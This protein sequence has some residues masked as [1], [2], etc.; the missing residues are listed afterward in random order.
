VS[1]KGAT[2]EEREIKIIPPIVRS[3]VAKG[4]RA[5]A[6]GP[7]LGTCPA[8]GFYGLAIALRLQNRSDRS[9]FVRGD[10]HKGVAKHVLGTPVAGAHEDHS[11][12]A[13]RPGT[14]MLEELCPQGQAH[15]HHRSS[16][17]SMFRAAGVVFFC[18]YL[19]DAVAV[20]VLSLP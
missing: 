10:R 13:R 17:P 20:S 7:G 15:R 14:F 3:L 2:Y 11:D 16:G 18:F 8:C 5:S 19:D 4:I 12:E 6:P 9:S 1:E